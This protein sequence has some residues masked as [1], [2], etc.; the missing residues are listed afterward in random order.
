MHAYEWYD[1]AKKNSFP[2]NQ[3]CSPFGIDFLNFPKS[4]RELSIS[5]WHRTSRSHYVTS[6]N[7]IHSSCSCLYYGLIDSKS[8][9][10]VRWGVL[11]VSLLNVKCGR[12]SRVG[13]GRGARGQDVK[14]AH[15]SKL[16]FF[17]LLEHLFNSFS[18]GCTYCLL[19]FSSISLFFCCLSVLYLLQIEWVLRYK[20]VW[21]KLMVIWP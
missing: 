4:N 6:C 2:F 19:F 15:G 9:K 20:R 10:W 13:I 5:L 3:I 18:V 1:S 12:M 14:E 7:F 21:R 11:E 8:P 16:L 17:L